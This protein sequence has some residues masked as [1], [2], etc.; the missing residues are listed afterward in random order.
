MTN[1]TVRPDILV[2][3]NGRNIA[4]RNHNEKLALAS[5]RRARFVT[6]KW[7][8]RD[9]DLSDLATATARY[10]ISCDPL[11]CIGHTADG[12]RIAY[13][14]NQAILE[15]EC[16]LAIVVISNRNIDRR[17]CRGPT[18]IIDRRDLKLHG[19]H[20]LTFEGAKIRIRR[21]RQV[22]GNR[23]WVPSGP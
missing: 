13:V 12:H 8:V 1:M 21:A 6:G 14:R 20:A 3:E 22:L 2:D 17:R 9:G 16:R 10:G 4:V 19:A 23:P 5:S 15:E 18:V 7:L 11:G